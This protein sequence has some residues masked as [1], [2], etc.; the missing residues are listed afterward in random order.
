MA[1]G[2]A[3]DLANGMHEFSGPCHCYKSSAPEP[4]AKKLRFSMH[5]ILVYQ[6]IGIAWVHG[7]TES[8]TIPEEPSNQTRRGNDRG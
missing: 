4:D 2:V 8:V 6:H 3:F 1:I 5:E 7:V